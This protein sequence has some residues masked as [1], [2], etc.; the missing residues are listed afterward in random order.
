[1]AE[2][3][4]RESSSGNA[5]TFNEDAVSEDDNKNMSRETSLEQEEKPEINNSSMSTM[6]R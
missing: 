1:M 4:R 3:G 5:S 6:N 2:G